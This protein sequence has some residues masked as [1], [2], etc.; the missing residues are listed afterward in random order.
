MPGGESTFA[1]QVLLPASPLLYIRLF[2]SKNNFNNKLKTNKQNN[3]GLSTL[4]EDYF[5][6]ILCVFF[7]QILLQ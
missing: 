7:P 4:S 5:L 2:C 3:K 6:T 1:K